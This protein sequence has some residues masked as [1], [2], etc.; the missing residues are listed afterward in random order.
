MSAESES[1]LYKPL[2]EGLNVLYKWDIDTTPSISRDNPSSSQTQPVRQIPSIM[3]G[4]SN[5]NRLREAMGHMGKEVV[6]ITSGGWS[7]TPANL[8]TVKCLIQAECDTKPES[9]VIIYGLD[10]SCFMCL[11]SAG[12]LSPITKSTVDNKY[13]VDGD[14]AITP[15]IL[16]KPMFDTLSEIVAIC[17]SRLVY[18]L[19]PLPRYVLVPCCFKDSHC[20]NL[21]VKD[22][23]TRQVVLGLMDELDQVCRL[24]KTKFPTCK[25]INTGDLL[26]G[27]DGASKLE[28]LDAMI[29]NWMTDPVHGDKAG[30]ARV[31]VKLIEKMEEK[32]S[33]SAVPEASPSG[34]PPPATSMASGS[35]SGRGRGRGANDTGR[36][37]SSRT[38]TPRN[39]EYQSGYDNR[40]RRDRWDMAPYQFTRGGNRGGRGRGRGGSRG[41]GYF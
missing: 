24:V 31:A 35:A 15:T 28:V 37:G 25:V 13:H 22:D 17:G 19:T 8:Q 12:Q 41:G 18:I 36:G 9:P 39:L 1:A 3:I 30:Y 23:A 40:Y 20:A 33:A 14:L 2:F 21:V 29:A 7:L 16:L 10:N 4:G 27:K 34:G 6:D 5:A 38:F 32:S 11:T 26:A